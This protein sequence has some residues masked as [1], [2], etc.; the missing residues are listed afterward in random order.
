MKIERIV[1]FPEKTLE[2][3]FV[4]RER[5]Y[6]ETADIIFEYEGFKKEEIYKKLKKELQI[7]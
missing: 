6:D 4:E 7:S 1:G 3:L 5:Y 2:E